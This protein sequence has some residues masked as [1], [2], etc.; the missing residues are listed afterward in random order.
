MITIE[1]VLDKI[2]NTLI[3]EVSNFAPEFQV[4][5]SQKVVRGGIL[6]TAGV[7]GRQAGERL[8]IFDQD[9]LANSEDDLLTLE[10]K[11]KV[12]YGD[13]WYNKSIEEI[14]IWIEDFQGNDT[15]GG[16]QICL[17]GSN[18]AN[19]TIIT[20]IIVNLDIANPLNVGQFVD[21]D[22]TTVTILPEQAQEFLDTN[23]F[24]LLPTGE[25]KQQRIT[26]FFQDYQA[27]KGDPPEFDLD[28]LPGV[29]PDFNSE[30]Y[31]EEH[32]I[33]AAQDTPEI[34]IPEE[35]S[36]I[37]RLNQDA[38]QLNQSKTLQYLRDDLN[39]FLEDVDQQIDSG[40][41]DDRPDYKA[42]AGGY[43]KIRNLNQ[44]II[45]RKQEGNDI[46][47]EDEI[48]IG[49]IENHPHS[50]G[51]GP[52]YLMDGFTITMWVRFL[53][54][55]SRGTLFNYGNPMRGID[56]K[57]FK[58]ETFVI[59]GNDTTDP[60]GD[61]GGLSWQAYADQQSPGTFFQNG[62][63]ERFIRLVVRD[64]L[65]GNLYDSHLGMPG[66]SREVGYD[67]VP[68]FDYTGT[69]NKDKG[70]EAFL[71]SHT[72]VPIDFNE[73]FFIVASYDPSNNDTDTG[74]VTYNITPEYWTGNIFA[75]GNYTSDSGLGSKCKVEVISKSDLLRARGYQS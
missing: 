71:L 24:E 26:K 29:D 4:P 66:F 11:L 56:P 61:G 15:F 55:T 70:D 18:C 58:L 39:T 32:D 53:D 37:T 48:T 30:A 27:L 41:V 12:E 22:E 35:D 9:T 16:Y 60:S 67:F 63:D 8:V 51:T 49:A 1:D 28:G 3:A 69:T 10:D 40:L 36:F 65:D 62:D 23:I 5:A 20:D 72:R 64:H 73:W 2:A 57:G 52:S 75:D 54:K 59:N 17:G 50:E 68:E 25:T 21:F 19:A 46:G 42:K 74:F 6:Q 14:G 33:S 44:G 38:N 47:I 31:S 13:T 7:G 43:L 34:G 45:I